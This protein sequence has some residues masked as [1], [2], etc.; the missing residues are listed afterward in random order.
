MIKLK[1]KNIFRFFFIIIYTACYLYYTML[2]RI[3]CTMHHSKIIFIN[4]EIS[5]NVLT[6]DKILFSNS[7]LYSK[8]KVI[9]YKY[10]IFCGLLLT[11]VPN[12]KHFNIIPYFPF[13]YRTILTL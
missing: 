9:M 11:L 12:H 3:T 13:E 4:C 7:I 8:Y 6:L 2:Y 1:K 10:F 5:R